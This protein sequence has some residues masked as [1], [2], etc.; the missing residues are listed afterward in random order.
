MDTL[1]LDRRLLARYSGNIPRYTSYPTAPQFRTDFDEAALRAAAQHSNGDPVPA[2]L[3]LYVHIPFCQSP[4]F[5]CG[6]NRVITR[7]VGRADAYLNRLYREMTL[8]AEL[9]DRDRTVVQMHFGGG[10]PNFLDTEQLADVIDVAQSQFRFAQCADREMSIEVDPRF[11]SAQDIVA[12]AQ[13]GVNRLSFG[14]QDFDPAVQ[15]AINRVQ[16]I[17]Q[18]L[19]VVEAGQRVGMRSINID[20]IYGLPKQHAAGFARTLDQVIAMNV[21]RLAVYSYAH[22]PEMF[23]PQQRIAAEDLPSDDEK[24]GL[25][26]LA[27]E[28]LTAAGYVYVGMDHF[29]RA[30]DE[31]VRAQR[32]G[33]LHRN[34][35]GYTTHAQ[36][37]LVGF[38]VSAI[39]HIGNSYSQ[40]HRDLASWEA[41]L[42]AG[43]L[44]LWRGVKMNDDD[45]IRADVIQSLMCQDE[46][47]SDR[48]SRRYGIDFN[49]YFFQSLA[50]LKPLIADGLVQVT[51]QGVRVL[52]PG[53]LLLRNIAA[54]FD[55][56]RVNPNAGPSSRHASAV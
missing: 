9:F 15:Q 41:T 49:N 6:C 34:F 35:M 18:T 39:S 30:D 38:G 36:T 48:I 37:D 43:R 54:C 56:A 14:V 11:A 42:D 28:R 8:A 17:E 22:L 45:V 55:H 19:A 23:R 31:L 16:S 7:D 5:Y 2:D 24:L 3:S 12:L 47:C 27:I 50:A 44:P 46:I 53:R 25:L 51:Q 29:A 26:E 10:T 40:N 1:T 20:L 4:C 52:G 33:G 21:S 13:A 32:L